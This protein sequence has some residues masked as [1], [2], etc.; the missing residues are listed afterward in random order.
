MKTSANLLSWIATNV[1]KEKIEESPEHSLLWF[2]SWRQAEQMRECYSTRDWA[3]LLL[4]GIEPTTL[5]SIEKDIAD[6]DS[7]MYDSAEDFCSELI[8]EMAQFWDVPAEETEK[9]RCPDCG[10]PSCG[11]LRRED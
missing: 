11:C 5:S 1:P 8:D 6:G 10:A 3:D 4:S 2:W 7:G 9:V